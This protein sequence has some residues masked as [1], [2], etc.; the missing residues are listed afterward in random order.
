M[1]RTYTDPEFFL[2][3]MQR[4]GT[5]LLQTIIDA[6]GRMELTDECWWLPSMN[7]GKKLYTAYFTRGNDAGWDDA[8]RVMHRELLKKEGRFGL[9]TIGCQNAAHAAYLHSLYPEAKFVHIIRDPRDTLISTL[10]TGIFSSPMA[11][12]TAYA[13]LTR[14][15]E[16]SNAPHHILRYEDLTTRPVETLQSLCEFL[17]VDYTDDM[18]TPLARR[19]SHNVSPA[20]DLADL[21]ARDIKPDRSVTE[22]WRRQLPTLDLLDLNELFPIIDELGYPVYKDRKVRLRINGNGRG[23][24]LLG[25]RLH[26]SDETVI[27]EGDVL[28]DL[29]SVGALGIRFPEADGPRSIRLEG[30]GEFEQAPNDEHLYL[31]RFDR[32]EKDVRFDYPS[33]NGLLEARPDLADMRLALYSAGG[34]TKAFLK[35]FHA[36]GLGERFAFAAILDKGAAGTLDGIP[37]IKTEDA[38]LSEYDLILITSFSYYS[39]ISK[40]LEARGLRRFADFTAVMFP[41]QELVRWW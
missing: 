6:S 33:W 15:Y 25:A 23:A 1:K 34:A 11:F 16:D 36:R 40:D 17:D 21:N 20:L 29:A 24:Q 27:H 38:D 2:V 12:R 3:G 28:I 13:A 5:T 41:N 35:E 14:F 39:E 7:E 37:I 10:R 18:L 31:Y 9:Q 4:S 8:V 30:Y 32:M 22:R 26:L 19:I